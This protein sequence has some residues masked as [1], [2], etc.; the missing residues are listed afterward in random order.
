MSALAWAGTT[1]PEAACLRIGD[2]ANLADPLTGDG[3]GNA[4]KSA[5]LVAE[6]IGE[7]TSRAEAAR[8]WQARHDEVFV[9][10]FRAA[11]SIRRVL[12]G[13]TAKNVT[14]RVLAAAPPLRVRVHAA[15]FGETTIAT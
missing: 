6:A 1:W 13:T 12:V 11:L 7:R 10:E 4:L 9:P 3:I 2:A 8:R 15:L 14:A 5:R